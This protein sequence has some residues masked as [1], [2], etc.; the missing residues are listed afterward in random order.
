MPYDLKLER[1]PEKRFD[2][3]IADLCRLKTPLGECFQSRA[4]EL[5]DHAANHH[6]T[7]RNAAFVDDGRDRDVA[8]D[9]PVK[10]TG[11]VEGLGPKNR[12][13]SDPLPYRYFCMAFRLLDRSQALEEARNMCAQLGK[14]S[15]R[16]ST[17]IELL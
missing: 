6:G 8:L 15:W 13:C 10:R 17:D 1:E 3:A 5:C 12:F 11:I 7:A 16:R 4:V 2:R 9:I 14:V